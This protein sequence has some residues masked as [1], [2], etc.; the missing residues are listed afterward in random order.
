MPAG[1]KTTIGGATVAVTATAAYGLLDLVLADLSL[2]GLVFAGLSIPLLAWLA[3][4]FVIAMT[5]AVLDRPNRLLLDRTTEDTAPPATRPRT[6][7][8]V[9]I[10][11]EDVERVVS[12][13]QAMRADL[14]DAGLAGDFDVFLL[15]DST[16]PD[17][18]LREEAVWSRLSQGD[19][20]VPVHYRHRP[21]NVHRKTGNVTDFVER[22]GDQYRY[23]V[24]LDADSVMTAATLAEMVDRMEADPA[25]GLLQVAPRPVHATSAFARCQQFAAAVYGPDFTRGFAAWCGRGGNY[26][27]HN[28]IVR[29]EAWLES[30]ALPVLPG[31]APFGGEILSHD[32]VEA[33]CLLKKG[34]DVVLADDLGGSYEEVPETLLDFAARDQ[35]WLQGNLQHLHVL[36]RG[37]FRPMSRWHMATGAF[38]YL[39][40]PLWLLAMLA[41]IAAVATSSGRGDAA[42]S[43]GLSPATQAAG[44]FAVSMALLFVPKF[45][46]VGGI[47]ARGD[48][49]A[50]GGAGRLLG[51]LAFEIAHS[52]LVAPVLMLFH[53]LFVLAALRG[54]QVRWGPQNRDAGRVAW[55]AATRVLWPHVAAGCVLWGL[56]T[57]AAPSLT[58]WF[59]P[60]LA[61]LA[62][63]VPLAVLGG[64]ER[65]GRRLRRL[66]LLRTPEETD[67][68][69]VLTDQLARRQH[70]G[71]QGPE[72]RE[73]RFR[74]LLTDPGVCALHREILLATRA[75]R[76]LPAS[77]RERYRDA[78]AKGG[79]AAF[80]KADRREILGD[81]DLLHELHIDR[82]ADRARRDG[83]VVEHLY[84]DPPPAN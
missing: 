49:A 43:L 41:G 28:A 40:S 75:A 62:L 65:L 39:A 78:F 45:V 44:L 38:A 34:W 71:R 73:D 22:W 42:T 61:G 37:D 11:N 18:W 1:L 16:E 21:E 77:T 3:F 56:V 6:A 84:A 59:T 76:P 64:D 35:R 23:M 67:P 14:A 60:V 48:A 72:G 79:L 81:P 70:S 27:G 33:A 68:P 8:V 13:V 58:V 15:S 52:V 55:A 47:V 31:A 32:F 66:G 50:F 83:R 82:W 36:A 29:T 9:P 5:G 30:A 7:L 24:V 4:G 12:G 25:L 51:S 46:A 20:T 69:G 54:K 19:G 2:W 26:W 57:L 10:Y 74:A 17:V 63:S 80:T 53:G